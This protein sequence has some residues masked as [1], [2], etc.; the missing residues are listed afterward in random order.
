M[1]PF[2]LNY[3]NIAMYCAV[4]DFPKSEDAIVGEVQPQQPPE[5][6]ECP[7]IHLLDIVALKENQKR[8]SQGL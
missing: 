4:G 8:M 5:A 7:V 2:V 1:L 6:A 3:L